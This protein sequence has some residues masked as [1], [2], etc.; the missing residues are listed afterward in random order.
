MCQGKLFK[1]WGGRLYGT[2]FWEEHHRTSTSQQVNLESYKRAIMLMYKCT[3][4]QWSY[5]FARPC[6]H[7]FPLAFSL[8][9]FLTSAS[10]FFCD[11][12]FFCSKD[13]G[14]SFRWNISKPHQQI[15]CFT[16]NTDMTLTYVQNPSNE[17]HLMPK[18]LLH[19]KILPIFQAH[20]SW[21]L[22]LQDH[23]LKWK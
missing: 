12:L 19:S 8:P 21:T 10:W 17:W 9:Q 22:N 13:R 11:C 7:F 4:V 1:N 14:H 18:Q 6:S 5:S 20:H 15:I 16:Y 23:H 3:Y 2:W